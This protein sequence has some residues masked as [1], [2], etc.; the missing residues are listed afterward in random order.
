MKHVRTDKILNPDTFQYSQVEIWKR[1]QVERPDWW[2]GSQWS[3]DWVYFTAAP[4]LQFELELK[5]DPMD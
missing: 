1:W 2:E 5:N 4:G 3:P